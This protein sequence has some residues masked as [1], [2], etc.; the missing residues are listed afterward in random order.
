MDKK[1][2]F[3]LL[4]EKMNVGLRA[5]RGMGR[6]EAVRRLLAGAGG[7]LMVPGLAAAHPVHKH[8]ADAATLAAADF[9]AAAADWTP[10]YLDAH[11]N[12]TWS[13]CQRGSFPDPTRRR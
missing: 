1:P 4:P 10:E 8:L 6:R 2:V 5:P 3:E 13:H 7:A 9:K 12:E 11:Q